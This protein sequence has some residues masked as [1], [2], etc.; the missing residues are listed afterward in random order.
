VTFAYISSIPFAFSPLTLFIGGQEEHPASTSSV[1]SEVQMICTWC[2]CYP[3]KIHIGSTFLV[4][5][6]PGCPRRSR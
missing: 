1:W 5:A 4:L 3:I 2:H 6:Y